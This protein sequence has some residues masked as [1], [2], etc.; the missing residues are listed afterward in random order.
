MSQSRYD[1]TLLLSPD[2]DATGDRKPLESIRDATWEHQAY[3]LQRGYKSLTDFAV[4]ELAA[5]V[6]ECRD[7]IDTL[8]RQVAEL[9][10]ASGVPVWPVTVTGG[11]LD[12]S[13]DK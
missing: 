12:T 13:E 7:R 11:I 5:I 4:D 3:A 8:E 10:A 1:R 2:P 9:R 6:R